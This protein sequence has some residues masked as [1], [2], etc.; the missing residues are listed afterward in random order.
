MAS[1]IEF[2]YTSGRTC[3]AQVRNSVGQI[4]NGAS[5]EAYSAGNIGTYDI[6]ATEQGSSGF[7]TAPM[8]AVAAGVYNVLAREQIGGSPAESD[9]TIGVGQMDWSGSAVATV[10]T[11]FSMVMTESYRSFQ[12]AGSAAQVLYEILAHLINMG[13]S[14][15]TK[16]INQLDGTPVK[17]YTL[18]SD[19]NPTAISETT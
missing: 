18:D 3:Y 2:D 8:P 19:T 12:A 10:A 1:E 7:Y 4:W 9:L 15:T 14:G 11:I 13:I 5:F 6:P 17:S 16:T